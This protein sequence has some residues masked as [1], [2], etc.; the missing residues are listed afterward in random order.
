MTDRRKPFVVGDY[1]ASPAGKQDFL[2]KIF[3]K[4]APH[5]EGIARWG[6]FGSGGIYRRNALLR[7]G[8]TPDMK[9]IDVAS[10]T[11]PVAR[12]FMQILNSA[13]QIVCVEPSAGM[14]AESRKTVPA[15]HHQ[16]TA[17][18]LPV[19]DEDFDFLAMGFALRHVDNLED[20]F[21]E[22]RRVLKDGGKAFIM[23]VT[24]P[25]GAVGRF[26]FR[27]YFK[28]ILPFFTLIFSRDREA[29]RLMKYYWETMEQM[30][31]RDEVVEILLEAGFRKAEHKVVLGCF[32]EYLVER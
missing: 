19:P 12:A 27:A 18:A 8:V 9:V 32:S 26:F 22:F 25:E 28:T 20:S 5:Y 30:T 23:D 4:T 6:W 3:D 17:E 24:M 1:Y 16:S 11:G 15:V 7:A 29:Y 2:R 10:G 31:H 21:R 13:D 14:I